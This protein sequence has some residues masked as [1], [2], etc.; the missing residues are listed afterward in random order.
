M[1]GQRTDPPY[2]MVKYSHAGLEQ[3]FYDIF[4]LFFLSGLCVPMAR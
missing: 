1:V 2:Y 3:V 4:L